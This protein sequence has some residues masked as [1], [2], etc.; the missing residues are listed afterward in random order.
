MK[1]VYEEWSRA[2]QKVK[3]DYD[4]SVYYLLTL[5]ERQKFLKLLMRYFRI[6][7]FVL[8]AGCGYGDKCV[9]F[10]K[11][12]KATV[13]GIDIVLEP[14][15]VLTNYLSEDPRAEVFVVNG[16]V[17]RLP[18]RDGVFD[19]VTSFGVVEHFRNDSELLMALS[20]AR[21]VLKVGGHLILIIPN[22][23][24]TLG[25]KLA[26]ALTKGRF[27]MY[28]KPYT[29]SALVSKLRM[30]N[31]LQIVECGFLPF[32]FCSLIL[33]VKSRSIEKVIYFL[34]NIVWYV[35]NF[36]LKIIGDDYQ[37]PIYLVAKRI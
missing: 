16:D 14:L 17:A 19:A 22:V 5:R 9:L 34:Y 30:I 25:H 15:K 33:I 6:G 20:E 12:M 2:W 3:P 27:G 10:N 32:G 24:N 8:E 31:G 37:N 35:P 26:M 23:V 7:A 11:C 1:K 29:R 18:F 4:K 21:R 28:H 13:V 36:I